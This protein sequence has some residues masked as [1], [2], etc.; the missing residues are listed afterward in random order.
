MCAKNEQ[1]KNATPTFYIHFPRLTT[2]LSKSALSAPSSRVGHSNTGG[3]LLVRSP[4][5]NQGGKKP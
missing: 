2:L 3:V 1:L 4:G 5:E